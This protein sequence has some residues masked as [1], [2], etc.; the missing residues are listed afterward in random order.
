MKMFSRGTAR[1]R[2]RISSHALCSVRPGHRTGV[3]CRRRQMGMNISSQ[4]EGEHLT[5]SNIASFSCRLSLEHSCELVIHCM[6]D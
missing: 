4:S 6:Y 3:P 1:G 2:V 5:G